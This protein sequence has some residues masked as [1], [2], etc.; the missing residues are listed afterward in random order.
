MFPLKQKR[1]FARIGK[2]KLHA[3]IVDN[4]R[5]LEGT[6]DDLSASGAR[7][8][9]ENDDI[10][11]DTSVEI[12]FSFHEKD[13]DIKAIKVRESAYKFI[14]LDRRTLALLNSDVLTDY[15]KDEPELREVIL[16]K[17]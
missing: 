1:R 2:L 10:K 16:K 12:R 14:D 4:E 3:T 7:I 15:F 11:E 6:I 17:E 8:L 13:Y 9:I 5:V